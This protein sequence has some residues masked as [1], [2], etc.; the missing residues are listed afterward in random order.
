[1]AI[2]FPNSPTVNQEF[3]SGSKT[4]IF[5]GVKWI[6]SLRANIDANTLDGFDNTYFINTSSTSQTKS[7]SLALETL[8]LNEAS[9]TAYMDSISVTTPV[10]IDSFS[11]TTYR[12]AEYL[13]QFS[14][15]G[16]YA[17]TKIVIIHNDSDVALT[18]YAHVEIGTTIPYEFSTNFSLGTLEVLLTLSNANITPVNVKFSRIAFDV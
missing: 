6:L 3:T 15:G 14:Q 17:T 18:E 1:M 2:D 5:D 13:L 12:S 9:I 7:G 11:T 16:N 4:W 10:L 8:D